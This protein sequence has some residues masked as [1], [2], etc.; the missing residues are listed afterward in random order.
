[1]DDRKLKK[2]NTAENFF[3][4]KLQF[5]SVQSTEEAPSALEREHP[6]LQIFFYV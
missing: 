2:K 3:D 6:A 4:P 5:T 1:L